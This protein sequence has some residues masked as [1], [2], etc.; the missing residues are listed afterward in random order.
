MSSNQAGKHGLPPL[1]ETR[2]RDLE[3]FIKGLDRGRTEIFVGREHEIE[4]VRDRLDIL[5]SRQGQPGSG[6]DLTVVYQGAPGAGKSA[7]LQRIAQEW[8]PE[9]NGKAVAIGIPSKLLKRPMDEMVTIVLN[10]L[11]GRSDAFLNTLK[12]LVKSAKINVVGVASLEVESSLGHPH[13]NQR[14]LKRIPV[15][16]MLLFDEIQATLGQNLS[17]DERK[18]L[19]DNIM[20]LHTGDHN[21][22]IF[23]VFGGLANTSEL[24]RQAGLTRLS[25]GSV[26]TLAGFNDETVRQLMDRFVKRYLAS[27]TKVGP[28]H[29][30]VALHLP[31]GIPK[32]WTKALVRDSQGWPMHC[33]NFLA[34]FAEEIRNCDWRPDA[35][36]LDA[37]RM[38]A[39][40]LRSDYYITRMDGVLRNRFDLTSALLEELQRRGP[41]KETDIILELNTM[42][43]RMSLPAG[44]TSEAVFD[45]MLH[46]GLIQKANRHA[47]SCPI[48][49]LSGYLGAL[50]ARPSDLLHR[51]VID[52]ER[53]SIKGEVERCHDDH[54]RST[55]LR[56]TDTRGRT[57]LILA[58]ESDLFPVVEILVSLEAALPEH[59]RST[60]MQD[61]AGRTAWDH[62]STADDRR[63][64][65]LL[66]SLK[67]SFQTEASRP[68][69]AGAGR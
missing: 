51:A 2:R 62:A 56:S 24:L 25:S 58:I 34:S 42:R 46:S 11:T 32:Q 53:D 1:D 38:R 40:R 28:G 45:A 64:S 8:A 36:D 68:N 54:S 10:N 44:V 65:A 23:P 29:E 13:R 7:L 5:L 37:L 55:L 48:P 27:E 30:N 21:L 26:R 57:P 69:D 66:A 49:S 39:Q 33:R 6:A 3:G 41:M 31:E 47:Y 4:L 67:P 17:N 35:I 14:H 50:T 20:S 18:N 16:V 19:N 43:E 63:I 12:D 52:A 61:H 9:R 22:P 15:P 59:L 60:D